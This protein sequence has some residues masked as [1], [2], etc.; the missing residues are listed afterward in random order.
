MT[1]SL[2]T[3]TSKGQITLPKAVREALGLSAGDP[4]LFEEV[5]GMV[6]LRRR[7]RPDPAWDQALAS[8]LGEWEDGLDDDL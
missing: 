6:T 5:N 1:P 3:V 8:T 2:A 4:V 7:P